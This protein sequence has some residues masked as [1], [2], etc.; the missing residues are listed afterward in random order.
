MTHLF[1]D[2][3]GLYDEFEEYRL[4]HWHGIS[5]FKSIINDFM[6]LCESSGKFNLEYD[7]GI[8]T[9]VNDFLADYEYDLEID[10]FVRRV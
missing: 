2:D 3:C 4:A 7:G 6:K 1:I 10:K 5:D 8:Y 9:S